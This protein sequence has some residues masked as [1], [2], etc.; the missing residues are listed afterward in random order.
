M[1]TEFLCGRP[2][3]EIFSYW[4][5][6]SNKINLRKT[7]GGIMVL[8]VSRSCPMSGLLVLQFVEY[9]SVT[10]PQGLFRSGRDLSSLHFC[11]SEIS[12]LMELFDINI[13]VLN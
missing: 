2:S 10:V 8:T 4:W 12:A 5:E 9:W 13:C 3:D 1:C 6:S 7:L 11:R